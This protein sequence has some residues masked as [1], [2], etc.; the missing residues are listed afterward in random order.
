MESTETM[1]FMK[2]LLIA[3]LA[4]DV[5]VFGV[6]ILYV[7][8]TLSNPIRQLTDAADALARGDFEAAA[9]QRV[10][11]SNA[12][13]DDG[14]AVNNEVVMMS[15]SFG[16][17]QRIIEETF[18][19]LQRVSSGLETGDLD[20][21]VRSDWSGIYGD[22]MRGLST[23]IGQLNSSFRQIRSVSEGLQQGTVEQSIDTDQPGEYGDVLSGLDSGTNQ[24]SESFEQIS[25]ASQGI[26]TASLIRT[27]TPIIP[28]PTELC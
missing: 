27:S 24:L 21:D 12:G 15:R 26:K 13:A 17:L 10:N 25:T 6:S 3:L 4:V 23:G 14:N 2:Q 8:R 20:S 28:V 9:L 18:N 19:E 22:V 16:Q 7:R 1:G 5:V 11:T